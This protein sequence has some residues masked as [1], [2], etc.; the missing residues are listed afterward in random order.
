MIVNL[1]GSSSRARKGAAMRGRARRRPGSRP[2]TN[3]SVAGRGFTLIELL[4]VIAI[5]GILLAFIMS[6]ALD[7]IRRAEDRATQALIT[8]L[9]VGMSD[10][11]D[12]ILASRV[13]ALPS[14]QYL[15]GVWAFSGGW[16]PSLQP[17]GITGLFSS[18]SNPNPNPN[19]IV[20]NIRAQII[21]RFDQV[22]AELPDVFFV[23][24]SD[25]NYPLNFAAIPFP[26]SAG[27]SAGFTTGTSGDPSSTPYANYLLPFGIGMLND[28]AGSSGS[29]SF[30]GNPYIPFP[31]SLNP[32]APPAL[33]MTSGP[34]N[35]PSTGIF[36]AS[37]TAA[38]GL[39]KSLYEAVQRDAA[40]SGT[41]LGA[42]KPKNAG[43][44]GVDNN[45]NGLVDEIGEND[46]GL[47][48]GKISSPM[49]AKLAKHTHKTARSEM[50]Y[51]LLVEGQ[52]PFGSVFSADDFS[53]AEVKDTDGDGLPEFVD[54]WGEP[55]Q[56]YRWPIF[57]QSD[58]QR[59]P[60]V[61]SGVLDTRDL[62]TLDPNQTL[63]DPSWWGGSNNANSPFGTAATLNASATLSSSA[64]FFQ[65]YFHTLTDP[66]TN[67][68]LSPSAGSGTGWDRGVATSP[69]FARREFYSR[70][71]I[72]SGGPDKTPGVPV[73]DASYFNTL[74]ASAPGNVIGAGGSGTY[75]AN[76]LNVESQAAPGTPARSAPFF[77]FN[78]IFA[79]PAAGIP[80][81]VGSGSN[82]S[83]TALILEAGHDDVSNQNLNNPGG[84]TQ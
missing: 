45:G 71:L 74:G 48:A 58:A 55:L 50:L 65:S 79:A 84:A 22:K 21:A 52:G 43:F 41:N 73:L 37:Y 10:R 32:N 34:V 3:A 49:K 80:V 12:A 26:T 56:F 4:V 31:Y 30:G 35:P 1:T 47:T 69:F 54:A 16:V 13:D 19:P 72:L 17:P 62:N 28:P 77:S 14:H 81:G 68:N 11:V 64:A 42:P 18:S 25:S 61:Y 57:F 39:Y 53:D 60:G 5:I 6:A 2:R 70:Y 38:A 7:G 75:T 82:D 59:G 36:G 15:A 40:A 44:D 33:L 9:D 83:V 66:N 76:D 27:S 67:P 51:A 24:S 78:N 63:V 29:V 20:N 46:M 8:K 23:Q